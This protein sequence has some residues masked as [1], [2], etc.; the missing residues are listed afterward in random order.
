MKQAIAGVA[1][2]SLEEVTIMTVWPT[3]GAIAPGRVLGRLCGIGLGIGPIL[4]IGNL[5][6]LLSIPLA[7]AM[8]FGGVMP[9]VAR[10]YRLTNRR[11]LIERQLFGFSGRYV[12][13]QSVSLDK[14]DT[15]LVEVLPGQEWYPAGNLRFKLG[16][17][18]T[19]QLVGVS[20]P[21]TFRQTCLKAHLSAVGVQKAMQ[22]EAAAR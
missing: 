8:Y 19:F 13:E 3:L 5:I 2:P 14:F 12:E 20:R 6:A 15:I 4:T 18:E 22:R 21:E 11:V 17:V 16:N 10:R 9:G 1:P 7:V